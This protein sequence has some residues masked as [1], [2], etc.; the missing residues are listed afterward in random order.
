MKIDKMV[1][2]I[3]MVMATASYA[4]PVAYMPNNTGGK[5]VITN[6]PCTKGK[7]T[8][9]GLFRLYTYSPN[10]D[11]SEGCFAFE[12]DT[13]RV[14]WPDA[15]KEYRYELSGFIMYQTK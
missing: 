4:E 3:L 9:E 15:Q 11:T 1:A 5:I 8:Y 6:E 7:K 10:G 12:K 14:F 2:S 13:I